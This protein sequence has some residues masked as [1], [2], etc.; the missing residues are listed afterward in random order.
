[1][2]PNMVTGE[3]ESTN[4]GDVTPRRMEQLQAEAF[5]TTA[6]AFDVGVIEDEFGS[7]LVL[8]KVHLSSKERQL[9][10]PIDEHLDAVLIHHLVEFGLF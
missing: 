4:V 7:Q 8:D 6:S 3:N 5:A 10:L 1:M 2:N 9:S